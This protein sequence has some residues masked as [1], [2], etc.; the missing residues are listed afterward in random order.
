MRAYDKAPSPSTSLCFLEQ[1]ISD[2]FRVRDAARPKG[3]TFSSHR[4]H[5]L[6]RVHYSPSPMNSGTPNNSGIQIIQIIVDPVS[7]KINTQKKTAGSASSYTKRRRVKWKLRLTNCDARD[8]G[9]K[10]ANTADLRETQTT[11]GMGTIRTH[12]TT[13]QREQD[14]YSTFSMAVPR[15]VSMAASGAVSIATSTAISTIDLNEKSNLHDNRNGV[16][17]DKISMTTVMAASTTISR[18][19]Q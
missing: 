11:R 10:C 12:C 15:A 17:N 7:Y 18:R 19:L 1:K 16:F 2:F 3:L 5:F 4:G 14:T 8:T 13:E 6:K 9:Q